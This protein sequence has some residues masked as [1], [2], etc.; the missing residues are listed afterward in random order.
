MSEQTKL[1]K[2]DI[3]DAYYF[4]KYKGDCNRWSSWEKKKPLFEKEFPELV[5]A[6][7]DLE[8]AEKTLVD[9]IETLPV[10]SDVE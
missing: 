5:K 8:L 6:L 10:E 7:N 1:T 3:K 4:I 9:V 2:T